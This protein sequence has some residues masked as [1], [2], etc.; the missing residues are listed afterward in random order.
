MNLHV[1]DFSAGDARDAAPDGFL[2]TREPRP[3]PIRRRAILAAHPEVKALIGHDPFTALV[4]ACVVAGQIAIA[5]TMGLLGLSYW[6]LAVLVAIFVGAFANHAMFVVIHDACH[7]AIFARPVWN[8]WVGILADLPNGAPTA[9]GFRYYHIKHHSHL[10]D[11]DYDADL[12]SHWE[13]RT[14]GRS[15]LGKAA[16]M[17]FFAPFQLARLGRL[18]ATVPMW[19][20]W[21]YVNAACVIAF[22]ILMVALFGPNALVYLLASFWFSIGGLHP[23]GARWVQEHFTHDPAQET[24]DYYGPLNRLALNIG[25]HNEHHD[26]P[27]VPWR[28][29]PALKRMAPEF[30]DHLKYHRSWTALLLKFIFDPSYTLYTRVDRSAANRPA[31]AAREG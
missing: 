2:K 3:H 27:D 8:K 26:F 23:L 16:W 11:Y 12:P 20:R 7:N 9:M 30:Y 29:L 21:T 6:W 15:A 22:D 25:Y 10:G 24:F 28:R 31:E 4:T 18:R 1:T 13:A 5:A 14:F 17:F 19:G